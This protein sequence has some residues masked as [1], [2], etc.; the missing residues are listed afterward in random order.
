MIS[1]YEEPLT[2]LALPDGANSIAGQ[3][4]ECLTSPNR[5]ERGDVAVVCR[6]EDTVIG[7]AWISFKDLQVCEARLF[8]SV[9]DDE[10]VLYDAFVF[11]QYRGRRVRARIAPVASAE[12]GA[13]MLLGISSPPYFESRLRFWRRLQ[14]EGGNA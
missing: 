13:E 3:P 10:A 5:F 4:F 9:R 1:I 11:P 8:L 7:Y 6:D 2:G 14:G 12:A